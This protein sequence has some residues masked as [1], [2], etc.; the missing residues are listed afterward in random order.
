MVLKL[1]ETADG[2]SSF[3]NEELEETYHSRH[4][5]FQEAK[6]V[7]IK[8]GLEPLLKGSKT[9]DIL[10]IGFGTG[11]NAWLTSIRSAKTDC[12]I[13]Y[14]GIEAFPLS[15]NQLQS[16]NYADLSKF[17]WEKELFSLIHRSKWEAKEKINDQFTLLKRKMDFS[18]IEEVDA[19]DLI[20]FDAFGP[21]VQPELWTVDVFRNMFKALRNKGVLV[22]YS[23]KGDVRR[24]MQS[25]G[26]EVERVEGPPGKR[27]MLVAKKNVNE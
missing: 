3:Y 4:G 1:I 27:E 21:L 7:F 26:F 12:S 20:Y 9:I 10:E 15:K 25:V 23:A 5:A 14:T 18:A 8:M 19:F 22:T 24:A 11:L 17:K 13:N 2:S 16:L 6:H